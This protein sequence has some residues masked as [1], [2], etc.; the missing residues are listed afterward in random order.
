MG[1]ISRQ[2]GVDLE[3]HIQMWVDQL[4]KDLKFGPGTGL[5]EIGEDKTIKIRIFHRS[6][7]LILLERREDIPDYILID[8]DRSTKILDISF[9]DPAHDIAWIRTRLYE[10]SPHLK[11]LEKIKVRVNHYQDEYLFERFGNNE[12]TFGRLRM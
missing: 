8:F 3:M 6:A 2:A 10:I 12:W 11:N 9:D 1:L 7:L 5:I 4:S